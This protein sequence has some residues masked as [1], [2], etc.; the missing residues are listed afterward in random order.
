MPESTLLFDAALL[1]PYL[2]GDWLLLTPNRRLASRIR[3]AVAAQQSAAV[4]PVTSVLALNDW[5]EQLWQQLQFRGAALPGDQSVEGLW[6]L[7]VAQELYLWEQAVRA[8]ELPLLRPAQ[9]AEQAASAYRILALWQQ[10]PLSRE[11]RAEF[12]HNPDSRAFVEWLD[13]FTN[14]CVAKNC[15]NVAAR[16][17]RVVNAV[18]AGQ[19]VLP[20]RVLGI[21]FDDL[22]PLAH[23]ILQAV[24]RFTELE[25]PNRQRSAVCV[26]ANTLTE[27]LQGAALW[28][29]Q[30]LQHT[31]NGPFAIVVPDLTQQRSLVERVLL[32]V[33]TP[34]HLLPG[35]P[36]QLPP[37]NFSA[38][39]PLAKTP[40]I[41]SALQLLTLLQ[42]KIER[43]ALLELLQSP[44]HHLDCDVTEYITAAITA[45]CDLRS[46]QISA[47]QLRKIVDDI[48]P[49]GE[50]PFAIGLQQLAELVRR[51]RVRSVRRSAAQWVTVFTSALELLGWPGRRPLDS[52]EYQQHE[53]WQ[54]TLLQFAQY[55]YVLAASN[56]DGFDFNNALQ[57]LRQLLQAQVFQPQTDDA[58][59]Q[60]LGV[61]EAAGLQ[62]KGLWLCD[63]SDDRWPTAA[64][65][66]PLIPRDLQRR[67]RMPRC[68]AQREY[69]IA[70]K[71]SHSLLANAE[72]V[73]ISYQREREEVLRAPSPLFERLLKIELNELLSGELLALLPQWST[74]QQQRALF[75]L[76]NF[77]AGSAPALS[78]AERAR[79]GSAL[80]KA[81]ADCPFQ[82]FAKLRLKAQP[83]AEPVVG[84]DA[85]ERG[86]LMHNALEWL[87]RELNDHATLLA[88]TLAQQ[89]AL[90]E[91]AAEHSVRLL[92][93]DD[94][95][96]GLR[97]AQLEQRRLAKLLFAW[98]DVER[99]RGAFVVIGTEQKKSLTFAHL[100]L[101]LRVDRID[102]LSDG[103]LLLIDY[104]SKIANS[105]AYEWLGER[106]DEP[107][108][109]LYS[110]LWEQSDAADEDIT[111]VAG[112][113]FAQVRLD[114]PR[115]VGLG[116]EQ[117]DEYSLQ[118]ASQLNDA[119][120]NRSWSEMKQHW[121]QLLE[122][123][124]AEFIRGVAD[125]APKTPK[126]CTYCAL[127]S[128]CRI[129]HQALPTAEE[130]L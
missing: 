53:H 72:Q 93:H 48:S 30:Q 97:F 130:V 101:R 14:L 114:N 118:A 117:L 92:Q 17:L 15:I 46:Q 91:R 57:R 33:L 16:D 108:L 103:R 43:A 95:R 5:L 99:A 111:E 21:G 4:A 90:V 22:P 19:L 12:E 3:S 125:V 75:A 107:Q 66:H 120:I 6:V 115:F 84:L 122:N 116:D 60:V 126:V 11:L 88:L 112:I 98:L 71:L 104:K 128:V 10:L 113:A 25:L 45:L 23:S 13:H 31:P 102:R 77:A 44:F 63:M 82:A 38:G 39:E 40:L 36:R 94:A 67:L 37:L 121:R 119:G 58:P 26:G 105:S 78:D 52:I 123:L 42:P 28:V 83:L 32:D 35:V 124:A 61:L 73:V 24:E 20:Q 50:W 68:D 7:S 9:A 34:Q 55:D 87:W 62:F 56:S 96:I 49:N 89:Q 27:Q 106:P 85:A 110:I 69:D 29:Q 41:Y 129:D 47:A 8:G 100:Q 1:S 109:P 86:N 79:G 54:R 80:F 127:A 2:G 51:E 59:V 64:A 70:V 81:Q 74:Q 76:E 65:P 18:R